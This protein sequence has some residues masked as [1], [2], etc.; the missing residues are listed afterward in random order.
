MEA[1]EKVVKFR[2]GDN[3]M[4]ISKIINKL[5]SLTIIDAQKGMKETFYKSVEKLCGGNT[6]NDWAE[7]QQTI[8]GTLLGVKKKGDVDKYKDLDYRVF[9]HGTSAEVAESIKAKGILLHKLG[10]E[11]GDF[12]G[13][14]SAFYVTNDLEQ[15][16]DWPKREKKKGANK[17]VKFTVSKDALIELTDCTYNPACGWKF[18]DGDAA[19]EY[20]SWI[21]ELLTRGGEVIANT[22][23]WEE[24]I[25]RGRAKEQNA[26]DLTVDYIEGPMCGT[27]GN[28]DSMAHSLNPTGHQLAIRSQKAADVFNK[29]TIEIVKK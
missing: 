18:Y 6:Y 24:Q 20:D 17:I 5:I 15:A 12:N 25:R 16:R 14:G 21:K 3:A 13:S 1:P 29:G 19:E 26:D 8:E 11:T 4:L 7:L 2:N 23:D 28:I 10:D 27:T 22:T 9:Y